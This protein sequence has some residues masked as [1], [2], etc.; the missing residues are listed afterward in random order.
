MILTRTFQSITKELILDKATYTWN[1]HKFWKEKKEKIW[2]NPITKAPIPTENFKSKVSSQ[3]TKI[4]RMRT[5]LGPSDRIYSVWLVSCGLTSHSAIFQLFSDGTVVQ[6]QNF[7][8]SAGHPTP[9]AARGSL[10][11]WA[12]PVTD[13]GTSEDVFN[14]IAIRGPT[15]GEGKPGNEP[16]SSDPQSS[17][18]PLRHRVG[19]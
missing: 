9:W 3:N 8:L 2:L 7:D 1:Y 10:A 17:P 4:L 15:L 12:Y 5:D 16:G 14:L 13:T 6:F 11:C 18:L 19:L